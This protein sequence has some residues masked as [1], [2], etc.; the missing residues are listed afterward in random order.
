VR[1]INYPL[2]K[3]ACPVLMFVAKFHDHRHQESQSKSSLALAG[4]GK[5]ILDPFLCHTDAPT[6]VLDIHDIRGG[7]FSSSWSASGKMRWFYASGNDGMCKPQ[8]TSSTSHILYQRKMV[9]LRT[10]MKT[11]V[12]QRKL[13]DLLVN[14]RW[15]SSQRVGC[16]IGVH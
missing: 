6:V 15:G 2:H 8:Q 13:I 16:G 3:Y 4:V 14:I 12:E 1:G 10:E 5:Y 9:N 11:P 7:K